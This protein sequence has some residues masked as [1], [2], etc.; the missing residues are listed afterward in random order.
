MNFI[1]TRNSASERLKACPSSDSL[2]QPCPI[3]AKPVS[4]LL[5]GLEHALE[6][7]GGLV[8]TQTAGNTTDVQVQ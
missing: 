8:R 4:S 6:S 2:W 3:S 7:P 5:L 1:L